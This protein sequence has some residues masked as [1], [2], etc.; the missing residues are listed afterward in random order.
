M[1][2]NVI[3][4]AVLA[5]FIAVVQ[6]VRGLDPVAILVSAVV[7]FVVSLAVLAV[8]SRFSSPRA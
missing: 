4:S 7:A 1:R 6:V 3:V 8:A 2:R 5:V